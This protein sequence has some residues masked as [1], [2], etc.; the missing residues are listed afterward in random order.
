M[1]IIDELD[2][3]SRIYVNNDQ[4]HLEEEAKAVSSTVIPPS[5]DEQKVH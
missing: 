3:I 2:S 5:T 1:N 4:D